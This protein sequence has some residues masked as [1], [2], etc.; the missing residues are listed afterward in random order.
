MNK[1]ILIVEDDPFSQDFYR[2]IFKKAGY[3]ATIM[4]DGD[5]ILKLLRTEK[6]GLCIMDI[7]LKNTYLLGEKIDGM[8]LSRI[9]KQDEVTAGIPILLVTAYSKSVTQNRFIDE[10]LAE[11]Y[12]TKPIIDFNMLL[13]KVEQMIVN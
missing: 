7:N 1:N 5:E 12:I 2:F 4:E 9:I 11:D 10:S 8:K 3:N 13:N 6:I